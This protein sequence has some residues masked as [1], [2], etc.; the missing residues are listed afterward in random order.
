MVDRV[1]QRGGELG[2]LRAGG[3]AEQPGPGRTADRRRVGQQPPRRLGHAPQPHAQGVGEAGGE[4][5]A[6]G[7]AVGR[8][9]LLGEQRVAAAALVQLGGE[10]RLRRAPEDPLQL[11]GDALG[12]ERRQLGEHHP[13]VVLQVGEHLPH[14][15]G[16]RQLARAEADRDG[17]PLAAQAAH[18]EADEL[19][20]GAVHPVDVLEDQQQRLAAPERAEQEHD[21]LEH[22]RLREA[23]GLR[24]AAH[25]HPGA[26]VREGPLELAAHL[27][28]RARRGRRPAPRDRRRGAAPPAARTAARRRP[29]A[30]TRR[31]ARPSRGRGRSAR[32]HAAGGSCRCP[33][34]R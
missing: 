29:G 20:R 32:P 3:G 1:P 28:A 33:P 6:A 14:R 31:A 10:R 27:G 34:H 9:Q 19:P 13:V 17:Q 12:A 23:I 26:E 18:E 16:A 7:V 4:L 21:R 11:G 2:L 25:G 24:A 15:V 5:L 30:G 8:E 22:A